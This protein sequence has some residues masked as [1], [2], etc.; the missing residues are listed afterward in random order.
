MKEKRDKDAEKNVDPLTGGPGAHPF[1]AG[2]GAA[3]GGVAGAAVGG[4]IGGAVGAGVGAVI[5]GAAGAYGGRGVAEA[6]N[7]TQEEAYWRGK[8]S[9]QAFADKKY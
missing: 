7:P 5:G 2:A 9:A 4:A 1:G 8:H 3:G 6:V